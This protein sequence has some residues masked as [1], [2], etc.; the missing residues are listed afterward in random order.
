MLAMS[1]LMW[2]VGPNYWLHVSGAYVIYRILSS[3]F[4]MRAFKT[5]PRDLKGLKLL[6]QVRLRMNSAFRRNR[7]LSEMFLDVVRENPD[8]EAV[9]EVEGGKRLTFTELNALANQYANYFQSIG[10]R[11]GDVVALYVENSAAFFA[12]WLGLSKVGIITAWINSNLKLE[13]LA[14]S[15]KVSNCKCVITTST[16]LPTYKNVVDNELIPNDKKIFLVD[17]SEDKSL[18]STSLGKKLPETS[19]QEPAKI[20]DVDFKSV[21]CYIYTSGTTGNPKP[22]IIKHFRYYMMAMGG[23]KAFGVVPS[24]R[25]Y[26]TLPMYHSAAGILGIGQCLTQGTTV[27]IRKKFSASNFWKDC[28]KHGCTASQYIGEICR[29]LLA[30]KPIP[31]EKQHNVRVMFGNGLR[32]ELW[33]EFVARYGLK[34][35]GELYGSTEGNSNILNIDNKVGACGFF[36]IYPFLTKLYPVR[37]VKVNE[38][39]GEIVRDKNGLCVSCRPGETG[40]MVGMIN[41]NDPLLHFEG[42]VDKS[43]TSKKILTDVFK[44]GDCVFTSGDILFWDEFGY[45]YFKD[46]RGDT[47][48][49]KGENVSTTEVESILQPVMSVEDATVY[50]VEIP[51]TEGRAGMAGIVLK[52]EVNLEDFLHEISKRLSDNLAAYAIPIFVRLCKEVDRTGTFK[53]KKTNLQKDAFNLGRCNGDRI[54]YWN[55]G[56]RCYAELDAQMQAAI[57]TGAYNKF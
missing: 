13:P 24:D 12:I 57:E 20:D 46:R 32:G 42:Y 18:D 22:A 5:L 50:G 4:A 27:V 41:K 38:E 29:Y 6:L 33:P 34:K 55:S 48:R 17:D 26:V 28:C 1:L 14:H 37:L 49:W 11:K 39:S 44:K 35:I 15:I 10:Y 3:N 16:L 54:F 2:A 9:V 43:D 19:T 52:E 36:P 53:L 56:Q 8:K 51:G 23:G 45:L 7:P 40:E 30:Q 25:L 47:F 31:E 21:L